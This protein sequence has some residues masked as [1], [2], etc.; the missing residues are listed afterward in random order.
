[1]SRRAS[2]SNLS[3][4]H[5]FG[6]TGMD[7]MRV[8]GEYQLDDQ[9]TGWKR[10]ITPRI[11]LNADVLDGKAIP[12][13]GYKSV[14]SL[15]NC[16]SLWKG[17]VALCVADG[18]DGAPSLY[19]FDGATATELCSVE[20]PINATMTYAEAGNKIYMSNGYWKKVYNAGAMDEW[21][22]TL[23]PMPV[24]VPCAGNLP[25]GQYS[26][27]YTYQDGTRLSGNGPILTVEWDGGE[28][29]IKLLN[30]P[31]D[32]LFWLSLPDGDRPLYLVTPTSGEVTEPY[33]AKPLP[34]LGVTEV[35]FL[36]N[37]IFA[38]GRIFGT[39]AGNLRFSEEFQYEWFKEAN[40]EPFYE[41]LVLV[42]PYE[43]GLY[44]HSLTT[45]W[46]IEGTNPLEWKI[47]TIGEG[48]VPG[49]L[50]Y[51]LPGD[52]GNEIS[53]TFS[54]LPSPVWMGSRGVVVGTNNGNLVHMTENQLKINP[55][56]QGAALYRRV[57]GYPQILM[58]LR[59]ANTKPA[60]DTTLQTIFA[61]GKLN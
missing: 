1:M 33:Y 20:G 17:S 10:R 46:A 42:A 19:Q 8:T 24:A 44:V 31:T 15:T 21:G 14:V 28:S 27:C 30:Q 59:G 25:A 48:A 26:M 16:H 29:G 56:N 11:V 45:S 9:S 36:K 39:E 38:H 53:K 57:N 32:A 43:N 5:Y 3:E 61:D 55:R 7:N 49:T 51:A 47:K 18:D 41:D 2:R 52:M 6:F 34:T 37:L 50:I 60:E 40:T 13:T 58:S 12:R 23:P 35:P 22:L 54:K 4:K